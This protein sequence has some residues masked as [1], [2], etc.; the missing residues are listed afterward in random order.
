MSLPPASVDREQNK[1]TLDSEGN[2]A[3][4]TKDVAVA[5]SLATSNETLQTIEDNTDGIETFLGVLVTQTD[6]IETKQDTSN[7]RI[8]DLTE[9]APA[10]DTASSGLN[11]RLQRIAQR[12]TSMFTALTDGS[13]RG[14]IVDSGNNAV[15]ASASNAGTNLQQALDV[16]RISPSRARYTGT[17]FIR[18]SAATAAGAV[19]WA[20]RNP[21]GSGKT[22]F[23]ERIYLNGDFNATT[24][25]GRVLLSYALRRFTGADPTGGTLLTPGKNDTDDVDSVVTVMRQLD[26]GLG[27]AMVLET[28]HVGLI[29]F[30]SFGTFGSP[31][32]RNETSIK[33]KPGEG[34]AI[35]LNAAAIVGQELS[36]EITWCVR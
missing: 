24:P 34:L 28:G 3:V 5:E 11:G 7:T 6:Q 32:V 19:V 8:G 18:Q 13:Q 16:Y 25:V 36:G 22:I 20:M 9:T 23:I 21:V 12:I 1:F 33:L 15:T 26:T 10:T 35:A 27:G 2:V 14:Q 29:G 31:Y 4:R 30:P 17:V